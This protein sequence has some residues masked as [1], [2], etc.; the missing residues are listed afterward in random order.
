ME[1]DPFKNINIEEIL[2]EIR[3]DA[4]RAE[5]ERDIAGSIVDVI[6]KRQSM[7]LLR[8]TK[9]LTAVSILLIMGNIVQGV[10]LIRGGQKA[11]KVQEEKVSLTNAGIVPPPVISELPTTATVI[12]E[13]KKY[14]ESPEISE[15]AGISPEEGIEEIFKLYSLILELPSISIQEIMS[16]KENREQTN[17]GNYDRV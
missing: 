11:T 9:L 17:G 8:Y 12:T 1:N 6:K 10:F 15:K 7:F 5:I 14:T 3:K 16:L 13:Q 4:E 2:V